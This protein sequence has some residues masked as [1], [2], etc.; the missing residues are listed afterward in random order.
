MSGAPTERLQK[1]MAAAGVASRRACEE[2]IA[3]GRVT[4]DREPARLGMKV[5]PATA[6]VRLD[7]E[8]V[9]LDPDRRYLMLNK[10]RGVVTTADDPAGRPT[11][12]ELVD[13]AE[14]VFPV[15]R[16]DM[17]TEGLLLLTNDGDLAHALTHPSYQVPRTYLALVPGPVRRKHLAA[18]REGVDLEDG[19]ARALEA[20]VVDTARSRA[21]VRIVMTEGRTREV[22]RMFGALGLTVDRLA[23]VAYDGVELGDLRQGNWRPLNQSEIGRLFG[24]VERDRA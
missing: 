19:L 2:L 21:L 16:L 9:A 10:P 15:G 20:E 8:R 18:L 1:A 4:V 13:V 12:I 6:E 24:A 17:D 11:V 14:R 23:R 7:G 5:D 22:R 3:Q